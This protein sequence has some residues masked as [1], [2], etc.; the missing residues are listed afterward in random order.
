MNGIYYEIIDKLKY[1]D[2]DLINS[3]IMDNNIVNINQDGIQKI[4]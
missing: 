2:I 1:K 4:K 3:K